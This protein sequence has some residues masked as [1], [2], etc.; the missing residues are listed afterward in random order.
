MSLSLS[1]PNSPENKSHKLG[2]K[3]S[4]KTSVLN[5]KSKPSY[6]LPS[7]KQLS[8]EDVEHRGLEIVDA[9]TKL[10]SSRPSSDIESSSE[11][12]KKKRTAGIDNEIR[13]ATSVL[14][15]ENEEGGI[16]SE[17]TDTVP[18]KKLKT[19]PSAEIAHLKA[20]SFKPPRN[21]ERKNPQENAAISAL[22][23]ESN[24]EGKE[25]WYFT[26]PSTVDISSL[27]SASSSAIICG[28]PVIK[29]NGEE[30]GFFK[31]SSEARNLRVVTPIAS[32]NGYGVVSR[33]VYQI[34][35]LQQIV[36]DTNVKLGK[37]ETEYPTRVVPSSMVKRVQP[38]GLKMRFHPLGL[39]N[40]PP[41]KMGDDSSDQSSS[42]ELHMN[43]D[44][45]PLISI[46]KQHKKTELR[47]NSALNSHRK[48]KHGSNSRENPSKK[49]TQTHSRKQ[50]LTSTTQ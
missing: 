29:Q 17:Q 28:E 30:Y 1:K 32:K 12:R 16:G 35:N 22:F 34:F 44:P 5:L 36:E 43:S 21:F 49:R 8:V 39:F 20:S 6:A 13:S 31:E 24:L 2:K 11:S 47:P 3:Q 10:N 27:K 23:S 46:P 19:M 40:E 38:K 33:P 48:V 7:T 37:S 15:T 14:S 41:V 45:S 26:M 42:E 9:K 50:S 18:T 25:I 4:S